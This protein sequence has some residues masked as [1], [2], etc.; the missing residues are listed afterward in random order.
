MPGG[1]LVKKLS[2]SYVKN[3]RKQAKRYFVTYRQLLRDLHTLE[4]FISR[5]RISVWTYILFCAISVFFMHQSVHLERENCM[6]CI[7]AGVLICLLPS[8]HVVNKMS[9][10][11]ANETWKYIM[12]LIFSSSNYW[13]EILMTVKKS[14]PFHPKY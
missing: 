12:N 10:S 3:R 5:I 7:F 6:V 14:P 11:H 13:F 2:W 9:V 4:K 8:D 1:L